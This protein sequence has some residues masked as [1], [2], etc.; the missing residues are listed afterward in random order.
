MPDAFSQ[1]TLQ[2]DFL[3]KKVMQNK[4]ICKRLIEEILD[5]KINSISFPEV[6]KTLDVARETKGIRLD[7]IVEDDQHTRYNLEMQAL[8]TVSRVT[9]ESLLPMRTRFY[10]AMLDTDMLQ[11]GQDYDSLYPTYIIFICGF[12]LFNKKFYQYTFR[13]MCQEDVSIELPDKTTIMFLNAKGCHG[14]VSKSLKAFLKYV[15]DHSVTDEFTQELH[16][17]LI[18]VKN[19]PKVRRDF[20]KYEMNL[21]DTF[22]EGEENGINKTI[23]GMIKAGIEYPLIA[24]STN[25]S[26]DKIKKIAKQQN[27]I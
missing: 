5:I 27:L 21:K 2:D 10:Q 8:N 6:E 18:Q 16:N 1:L 13:K 24:K 4:R 14:N 15:D 12:D 11:K 19:D 20:M 25:Y 26:I 23:I 22:K 9:H 17:E 3:F 7:V